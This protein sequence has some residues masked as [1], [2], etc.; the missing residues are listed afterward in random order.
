MK[1]T[2]AEYAFVTQ[3]DNDF[4][5]DAIRVLIYRM[6]GTADYCRR[7]RMRK[8]LACGPIVRIPHP[9]CRADRKAGAP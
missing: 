4:G 9:R 7:D 1:R 8:G 5:L 2:G 3:D 6:R